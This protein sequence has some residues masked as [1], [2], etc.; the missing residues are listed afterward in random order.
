VTRQAGARPDQLVARVDLRMSRF[1]VFCFGLS[2]QLRFTAQTRAPRYTC[3]L[4]VCAGFAGYPLAYWR[5][6]WLRDILF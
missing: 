4:L 1:R 2:E 6:L 5:L 3:A